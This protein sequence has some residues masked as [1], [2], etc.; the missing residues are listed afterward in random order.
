[1][2]DSRADSGYVDGGFDARIPVW[3]AKPETWERF[4]KDMKW[5]QAGEDVS[6]VKFNVGVR[7]VKRQRGVVKSRLEEFEPS[8][9]RGVMPFQISPADPVAG[10]PAVWDDGDVFKGINDILMPSLGTMTGTDDNSEKASLRT[11]WH[12]TL[13]RRSGERMIDWCQ[14]FRE[15]RNAETP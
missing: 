13:F 10:T 11:G 4:K 9:I 14:R 7:F 12:K 6:K 3:D 15:H 1:M 5:W 2:L 8:A